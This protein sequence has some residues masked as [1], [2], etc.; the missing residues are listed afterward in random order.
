[1]GVIPSTNYLKLVMS[2]VSLRPKKNPSLSPVHGYVP[3]EQGK[4]VRDFRCQ[5]ISSEISVCHMCDFQDPNSFAQ[6]I[7]A[8]KKPK[9]GWWKWHLSRAFF[10]L[11]ITRHRWK[12]WHWWGHRLSPETKFSWLANSFQSRW[13]QPSTTKNRGLSTCL[14]LKPC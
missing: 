11:P 1:M 4:P 13:Q 14:W 6:R 7:W 10:F 3:T 2:C 5:R 8:Q 12:P 9:L